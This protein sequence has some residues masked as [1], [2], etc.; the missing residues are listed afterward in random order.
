MR[1]LALSGSLRSASWNTALARELVALAPEGVEAEIATLHGIPVYDGDREEAEGIPE[2]VET[3]KERIVAADGLILVT[4]EYNQGI[5]GAFKNAID[6]TTR[7]PKDIARVFRG[8][9]VALCGATPG[10]AGTRSAQ[11]AWLPTLRTLGTRL[12]SEHVLFVANAADRFD[13]QGRLVD[14]NLR[15][16]A[17]GLVE[18]FCAF[19]R[20]RAG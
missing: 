11:Y 2:A 5:P 13:D 1:I 9:P 8:R 12:Y 17:A 7:P 4:P 16:R 18:G 19:C 14:E 10:G 6:W 20:A 15:K 3:L